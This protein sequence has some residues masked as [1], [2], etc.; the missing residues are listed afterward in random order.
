MKKAL[1]GSIRT[2]GREIQPSLA[3]TGQEAGPCPFLEQDQVVV[4]FAIPT[5]S[6]V[7]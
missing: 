6:V 7:Y 3:A 5:K 2:V 4:A 1:K